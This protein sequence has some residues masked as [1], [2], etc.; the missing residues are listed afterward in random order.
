MTVIAEPEFDGQPFVIEHLTTG[1]HASG[2][3][4]LDDGRS[5]VFG[6]QRPNLVVAVYRAGHCDPVPQSE[7]LLFVTRRPL[8]GIDLADERSLAAAVRDA[9][10]ANR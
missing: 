9:V 3:G 2:F 1:V 5:F 4:Y 10:R 8:L 6:V 7:D